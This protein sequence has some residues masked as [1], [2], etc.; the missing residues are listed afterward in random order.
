M[1]QQDHYAKQ[2][3]PFINEE[4]TML[5]YFEYNVVLLKFLAH[6][7]HIIFHGKQLDSYGFEYLWFIG[8]N[9]NN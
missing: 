7:Y 5:N 1:Q 3:K 2:S 6:L 4:N 8:Y 9:L